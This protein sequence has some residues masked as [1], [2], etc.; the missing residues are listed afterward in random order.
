MSCVP[1]QQCDLV[2]Q[3]IVKTI[4]Q[5]FTPTGH[6]EAD[7]ERAKQYA[8]AVGMD[9]ANTDMAIIAAT[10]GM[11]VAAKTM[12]SNHTDTNGIF[13]YAAMRSTYG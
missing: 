4:K 5:T 13:D 6:V 8:N 1:K 2:A 7:T 3:P 9:K 11:D 12:I 10:Q